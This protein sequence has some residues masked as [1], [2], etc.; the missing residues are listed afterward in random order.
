L[1][2]VQRLAV[3]CLALSLGSTAAQAQ[4]EPPPAGEWKHALSLFD[5]VKYPSDFKHFDYV[6]PN[7]PKGGLVRLSASG[8]YDSFNIAIPRGVVA[9]GLT[10]I[11]ETLMVEAQDEVSTEYGLLAEAVKYPGDH[12]SVTYRL[13]PEAR[14]QDGK[15]LTVEDVVWSFDVLKNNSP[16]FAQYYRNV[17]K[18]ETSDREVTFTFAEKGNRELPQIIGQLIVMPKHWWTGTGPDG[19]PRDITQT[20]LEPPLGSGPY[21]I[22]AG[23]QPGRTISYERVPDYWGKDLPVMV[24][25]NNFD[26]IRYDYYRDSDVALEAF[27]AGQYDFRI[28]ATA[29]NWATAYDFPARQQGKVVL[30]TYP[31]RNMGLMQAFVFNTRREKFQDPRVRRAFDL[32]MNFEEMNKTLFFNQYTRITSYFQNT[33]LAS[34]GLPKGKELEILNTVKDQVP[35]EV[36]TTAYFHPSNADPNSQR[37]NL[38]EAVRLMGEAGWTVKNVGGKRVMTNAKG[39]PLTVEVLIDQPVFERV[40]LFYKQALDRLGVDV[41]V[42]SVDDAQYENRVNAFDFDMIIAS[43]GESLSPGNE[44]REFWGSAAADRE[45]SRNYAGIK[46]P[47]VDKLIERLIYSTDREDLVAATRALDR[48]LLWNNYV[49]PNWTLDKTRY[50]YWNRFSRP[51]KLPEYSL[52]FP[53]VWW[54][55]EAKAASV[56]RAQ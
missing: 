3:L 16:F 47:A 9:A 34:S 2:I 44:Q 33:E 36:F 25:T 37:E 15:P 52:G 18:V 7:A 43:W 45:G 17:S 39:E 10:Q 23:F 35:P 32:V 54:Y 24:G 22:K 20:T 13:R 26:E 21:R 19:K 11:Y 48:V 28:E 6:N 40:V 56:G 5:S 42:R 14:W 1:T 50:A 55:D 30:D 4:T 27:K 38:R 12:S 49:V 46:N 29:K 41:R 8:G 51:E 53:D 31:I